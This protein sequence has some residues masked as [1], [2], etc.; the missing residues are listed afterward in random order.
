MVKKEVQVTL[1]KE[2]QMGQN[3]R[4]NTNKILNT[5]SKNKE[6]FLEL[7]KQAVLNL[8]FRLPAFNEH[9]PMSKRLLD[10]QIIDLFNQKFKQ[11]VI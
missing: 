4:V 5:L 1:K 6:L 9:N 7:K 8:K 10:T 2:I 3:D 11:E